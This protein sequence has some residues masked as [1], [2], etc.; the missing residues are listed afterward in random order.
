MLEKNFQHNSSREN[1]E[2]FL[3]EEGF[4]DLTKLISILPNFITK[5]VLY[6]TFPHL[7]VRIRQT[8]I[9]FL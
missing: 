2:Y 7:V 5:N 8:I 4:I 1:Q 9:T 6:I 3:L